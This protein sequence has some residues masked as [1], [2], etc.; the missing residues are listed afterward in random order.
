[1]HVCSMWYNIVSIYVLYKTA[2]TIVW[3]KVSS[4]HIFFLYQKISIKVRLYLVCTSDDDGSS[5]K[6][7]STDQSLS[8]K[9]ARAKAPNENSS[10]E[11]HHCL[12]LF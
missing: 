1:M 5:P 6:M 12:E 8:L 11:E 9:V 4:T 7:R 2:P 10:L 3:S